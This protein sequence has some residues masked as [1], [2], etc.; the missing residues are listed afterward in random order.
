MTGQRIKDVMTAHPI[1]VPGTATVGEVAELM[2]DHDIGTVLIA[3]ET[4]TGLVTDRDLVVRILAA[5]GG[6]QTEVREAVTPA[7]LCLRPEDS[8]QAAIET[9]RLHAVRRIPVVEDGRPV[10]IVSIGDLAEDRDP[11]SLLGAISAAGP[12]H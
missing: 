7:P 5:D 3:D 4:T 12:N 11:R 9:M 2:R 8:V 6:P 1:V 10:G